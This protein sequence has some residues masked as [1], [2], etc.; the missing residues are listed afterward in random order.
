MKCRDC[1]YFYQNETMPFY[2]HYCMNFES[3][4]FKEYVGYGNK[5][6][7]KKGKENLELW[8]I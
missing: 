2:E 3:E 7:C 1:K 6:E 5:Y 8:K 4:N